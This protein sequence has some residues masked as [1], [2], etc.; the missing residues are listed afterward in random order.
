MAES[1]VV[2]VV[3]GHFDPLTCRGLADA[4]SEDSRIRVVATDLQDAAL[5]R[6]VAQKAPKVA[7]VGDGVEQSLIESL[8]TSQPP[9]GAVVLASDPT[10]LYGTL[11]LAAGAACVARHATTADILGAI[12]LI[13]Q[14][15]RVFVSDDGHRVHRH[16]PTGA[17]LLTRREAEVLEHLS[18][19][20]SYPEIALRLKIGVETVRTHTVRIRQ[21]LKVQSRRDLIGMPVP[22][23]AARNR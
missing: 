11:L 10:R 13:A 12:H 21:K 2:T 19:G 17:E 15:K 20:R 14:G 9:T 22:R 6:V 4:L 1:D 16:Y 7:I 5:E 3:I 23:S 18:R 8:R